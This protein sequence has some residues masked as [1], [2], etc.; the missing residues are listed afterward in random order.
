MI[1]SCENCKVFFVPKCIE[2]HKL[3]AR[4]MLNFKRINCN[5]IVHLS[6]MIL[7]NLIKT[8]WY[9]YTTY[10]SKYKFLTTF[11]MW[12]LI[13]FSENGNEAC[14]KFVDR[15]IINRHLNSTLSLSLLWY[16]FFITSNINLFSKFIRISKN[17][18]LGIWTI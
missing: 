6:I 12:D 15:A 11:V 18:L 9:N 13:V 4:E 2:L 1:L 14:I 10:F 8:N 5:K 16:F 3:H 17:S 7:K